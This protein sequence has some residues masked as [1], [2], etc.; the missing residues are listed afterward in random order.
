MS[1]DEVKRGPGRP[2]TIKDEETRVTR[3]TRIPMSEMG[4]KLT[5]LGKNP[6]FEYYWA[7]DSKENGHNC[8]KFKLAGWEFCTTDEG[9]VIGDAFVYNTGTE[10]S[11]YRVPA[12]R[13]DEGYLFLMK[14]RK[15]WYDEDTK[16]AQ[17][18]I[19]ET[20][21]GMFTPNTADGQ[22][23]KSGYDVE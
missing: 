23:G 16:K 2:K 11:V 20:E 4:G 8:L 1:I 12:G 6:D 22:Y 15:E 10:G 13:T 17:K 19:D 7:Y 14:I 3:P 9:L 5:V 21:K 18:R